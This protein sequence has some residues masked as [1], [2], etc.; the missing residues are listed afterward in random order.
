VLRRATAILAFAYASLH[1]LLLLNPAYAPATDT[2][3]RQFAHIT[4][5]L[6]I[7]LAALLLRHAITFGV[8][9]FLS[10]LAAASTLP[11]SPDFPI[12]HAPLQITRGLAASALG[13]LSIILAIQS[14]HPLR[15]RFAINPDAEPQRLLALASLRRQIITRALNISGQEADLAVYSPAPKL[16][17]RLAELDLTPA[18]QHQL[19]LA[20]IATGHRDAFPLL[21]KTLTDPPE[22]I[23]L[24]IFQ[25]IL[26]LPRRLQ[27]SPTAPALSNWLQRRARRLKWDE[28][29]DRYVL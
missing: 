29:A 22:A 17:A 23:T 11:T 19:A 5:G 10:F 1:L 25:L 26:P 6:A 7:A 28:T 2:P 3:P 20:L 16:R 27:K 8:L 18:D 13:I 14:S 12:T 9:C 24:Q 21:L 15:K 4:L